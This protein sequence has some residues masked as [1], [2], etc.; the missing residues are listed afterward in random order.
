MQLPSGFPVRI[1]IPLFHV[2]NA[3]ITF[4][5]VF[6]LETPVE[7]VTNIKE[8]DGER[9]TCVI[10]DQIFEIPP[11]YVKRGSEYRRQIGFENEDELLQYAIQQS[12]IDAGSEND[13][14]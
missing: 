3:V 4:G 1:E 12:L 13:E 8:E 14:V 6:A 9:L 2:V 10:D 5:N 11:N 7:M